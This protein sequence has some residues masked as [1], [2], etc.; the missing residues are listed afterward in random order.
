MKENVR[1]QWRIHLCFGRFRL[2]ECSGTTATHSVMQHH[3]PVAASDQLTGTIRRFS[4]HSAVLLGSTCEG[5]SE[6][7]LCYLHFCHPE[8]SHSAS[9]G[10][11]AKPKSNP[12]RASEPSAHS[13]K[14]SSTESTSASSDS[15]QR[16]SSCKRP[17]LGEISST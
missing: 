3:Q 9:A 4:F 1:K 2:E 12:L 13:V 16:D 10:V 5:N 7:D 14:S 8:W 17:N 15:S 11:V 6:F